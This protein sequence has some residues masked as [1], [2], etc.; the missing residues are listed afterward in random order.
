MTTRRPKEFGVYTVHPLVDSLR[1][2]VCGLDT[3][4]CHHCQPLTRTNCVHPVLFSA[5]EAKPSC[6]APP[7][8]PA[9]FLLRPPLAFFCHVLSFTLPLISSHSR[10][11]VPRRRAS[12]W[13]SPPRPRSS[14]TL[15]PTRRRPRIEAS[16]ATRESGSS[17]ESPPPGC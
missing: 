13:L 2:G 9:I 1:F 5:E 12:R 15:L 10:R 11:N 16:S 6:A 7:H 4:A 17:A 3:F 14:L 8:S